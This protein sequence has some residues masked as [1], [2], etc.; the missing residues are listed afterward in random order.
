MKNKDI[1]FS[2]GTHGYIS[3]KELLGYLKEC[4]VK[5]KDYKYIKFFPD[6]GG[7]YYE[8]DDIGIKACWSEE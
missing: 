3:L 7:V 8:G 5:P 2:L 6:Y 4:G 1:E